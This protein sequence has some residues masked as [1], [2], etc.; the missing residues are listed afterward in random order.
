MYR[1]RKHCLAYAFCLL[2]RP[3]PLSRGWIAEWPDRPERAARARR[4]KKRLPRRSA[5]SPV[6]EGPSF[7]P[8]DT[9]RCIE[10]GESARDAAIAI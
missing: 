6:S 3:P 7:F 4:M 9:S 2:F 10:R 5:P 1:P 8:A